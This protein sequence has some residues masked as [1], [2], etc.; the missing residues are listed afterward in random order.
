MGIVFSPEL[1]F[2]HAEDLASRARALKEE[3]D[4]TEIDVASKD[5][6]IKATFTVSG[7]ITSLQLQPSATE[8]RDAKELAE[9]VLSVLQK[10]QSIGERVGLEMANR[11]LPGVPKLLEQLREQAVEPFDCGK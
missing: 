1:A 5:G 3:A 2:Q 10:G 7:R 6:S 8:S 9:A 11:H 4:D